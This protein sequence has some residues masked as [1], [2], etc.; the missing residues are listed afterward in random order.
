MD[1]LENNQ[2]NFENNYNYNNLEEKEE[3]IDNKINGNNINQNTTE[4]N[5]DIIINNLNP[6]ISGIIIR[7]KVHKNRFFIE[8]PLYLRT[9][10]NLKQNLIAELNLTDQDFLI[11]RSP[12]TLI[13]NDWDVGRL[14]N[15][16]ELEI[17]ES[18]VFN[19]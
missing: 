10:K 16:H 15:T 1:Q 5:Q 18:Q 2:Q 14:N 19:K 13:R 7:A 12:N 11:I 6:K 8:F 17:Y 3:H 4:E 9:I